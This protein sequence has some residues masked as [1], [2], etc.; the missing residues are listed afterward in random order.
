M[1]KIVGLILG[2][3]RRLF[4]GQTPKIPVLGGEMVNR[5]LFMGHRQIVGLILGHPLPPHPLL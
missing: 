3:N 5:R 4:M 1:T 2:Q